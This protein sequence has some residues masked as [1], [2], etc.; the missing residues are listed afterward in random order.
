MKYFFFIVLLTALPGVRLLASEYHLQ[1]PEK[2]MEAVVSLKNGKLVYQVMAAGKVIIE[3]SSLGLTLN[4]QDY[5]T[6]VTRL[7]VLKRK[8]INDPYQVRGKHI[9]ASNRYVAYTFLVERSQEEY[10]IEFRLYDDG[11]AFRY[12]FEE[13]KRYL[14][15]KEGSS[16]TLPAKSR[17]WYFERNNSWKLK[18]YAGLW[19]S[20][21]IDSLP[22]ISSQ[23]PIQGKPL[24]AVLEDQTFVVLTEAALYNYS[25]LRF[26]AKPGRKLEV[27]F[28]EGS[29]GFNVEGKMLTP[30]RV[31]LYAKD[32]NELVNTDVITNLNPPADQELYADRSYIKPGK[33][34]WSWLSSHKKSDYLQPMFEKGII[35]RACQLGF[36]YTMIDEG[37]E[38]KWPQKWAQLKELCKYAEGKNVGVWVWKHSKDLMNP[39]LRDVFLDSVK[40]AGAVGVKTD[41]M[42]SEAKTLIDFEIGFLKACA[43]RKL[44]VNFHGCHTSTGESRTYPNELT[45]EGVRGMELNILDEPIPAWHN[46]ALPFTRFI[47]GHGDYTPGLFSNKFNT[48]YTQQLAMFYLL[49]SSF[50]CLADDPGYL[51]RPELKPIAEALKNLPVTWDETVVLP[52]SNIGDIAAIARRKGENWYMAIINGKQKNRTFTIATP[53]LTKHKKY[54]AEFIMDNGNDTLRELNLNLDA[55]YQSAHKLFA[56]GGIVVRIRPA[57]NEAK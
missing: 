29:A 35:D 8:L 22:Y 42:N 57:K 6:K 26:H 40:K 18:S 51:T 28:T 24:I 43:A 15:H 47:C 38:S 9:Q 12:I 39:D 11:C 50:Q 37:W 13:E 14:I 46:A 41:F 52:G 1:S 44:M 53:F 34:V 20:T 17:I 33:A 36:E 30:W 2:R 27:N 19:Q 23:G 16:F 3:P 56:N 49:E 45:R 48:T 54:K 32:L 5:G 10:T 7:K 21:A 4:H 55:T 31:M 25:G